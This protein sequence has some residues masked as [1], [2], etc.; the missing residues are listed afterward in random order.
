MVRL[1]SFFFGGMKKLPGR[2]RVDEDDYP[3]LLLVRFVSPQKSPSSAKAG[4]KDELSIRAVD[5]T[6]LFSSL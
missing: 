1:D 6:H 3:S 2:K 5:A 4:E